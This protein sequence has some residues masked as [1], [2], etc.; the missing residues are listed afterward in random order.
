MLVL[1]DSPATRM[2]S[3]REVC[4]GVELG[5]PCPYRESILVSP[6]QVWD[7]GPLFHCRAIGTT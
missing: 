2:G 5:G 6:S 1:F 3:T 4:G 7:G